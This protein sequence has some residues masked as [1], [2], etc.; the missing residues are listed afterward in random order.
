MTGDGPNITKAT[1]LAYLRDELSDPVTQQWLDQ[2]FTA[3]AELGGRVELD[4][5][6]DLTLPSERAEKA[7]SAM[8]TRLIS[9]SN[10]DRCVHLRSIELQPTA[11]DPVAHRQMC[12]DCCATYDGWSLLPDHLTQREARKLSCD[13]CEKRFTRRWDDHDTGDEGIRCETR[14]FWYFVAPLRLC[15]ACYRLLTYYR[16]DLPLE[17]YK[18]VSE[19]RARLRGEG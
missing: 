6:P 12:L 16:E 3:T 19:A 7:F 13:C 9:E 1:M 10:G 2:L 18:G 5:D 4:F 17:I 11:I 15:M 8:W 14:R